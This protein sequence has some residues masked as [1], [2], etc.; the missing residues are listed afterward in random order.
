MVDI[1]TKMFYGMLVVFA[2]FV[3]YLMTVKHS[4]F[5]NIAIGLGIIIAISM[6]IIFGLK[7]IN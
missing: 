2:G 1:F 7:Y 4:S 3:I 5:T 6:A